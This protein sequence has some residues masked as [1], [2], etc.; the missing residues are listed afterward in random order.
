[1]PAHWIQKLT[2][3]RTDKNPKRWSALT[4]HQAPHKPFLLLAIMDLMEAGRIAENVIEPSQ[5][6][7][8]A[9]GDYWER[10]LPKGQSTMAYPFPRLQGDKVLTLIPRPGILQPTLP[11]KICSL[12][13]LRN[14]YSHARLDEALYILMQEPTTR[15]ILR[16]TLVTHYFAPEAR[17]MVQGTSQLNRLTAQYTQYLL[18]E[19]SLTPGEIREATR[20]VVVRDRSFRS[21][22]LPLYD[23]RCAICRIRVQTPAAHHMVDA[24]HI[25]PFA[26]THDNRPTNGL[27]LCKVCHWA[28]DE[29]MIG[30]DGRYSVMISKHLTT[31]FNEAGRLPSLKGRKI[32]LPEENRYHPSQKNLKWHR[33]ETFIR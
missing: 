15:E 28:F 6:L 13:R 5:E 29:G 16:S 2:H 10:L 7:V 3:L 24:A 31:P 1:M 32:I 27:S 19:E 21:A 26:E 8:E 12:H 14:D 9:F 11:T 20:T 30:I 22:L 18:D 25:V 33:G 4:T 23:Y 17:A